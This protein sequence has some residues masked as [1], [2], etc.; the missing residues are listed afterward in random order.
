MGA[1]ACGD[2]GQG[3]ARAGEVPRRSLLGMLGLGLAA[4]LAGCA[5]P[6]GAA[7]PPVPPPARP[8][9]ATVRTTAPARGAPIALTV[10]DGYAPH[11]VAGYVEFARRAGIHLTFSPNG[12]CTRR[13]GRRG[14]RCCGRSS[15]PVRC[16][17]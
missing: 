10:D 7:P 17:S 14:R 5:A 11:V 6:A 9:T 1:G 8:A 15:R 16:R 2:A 3:R 12:V 4:W 13:R